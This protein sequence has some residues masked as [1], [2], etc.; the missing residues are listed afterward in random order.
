MNLQHNPL[1]FSKLLNP[2]TGSLQMYNVKSDTDTKGRRD[3]RMTLF[4]TISRP[5]DRYYNNHGVRYKKYTIRTVLSAL[6]CS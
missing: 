3:Y 1:L 5:R 4:S 6:T 2:A